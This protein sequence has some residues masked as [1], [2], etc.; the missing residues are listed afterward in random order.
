MGPDYLKGSYDAAK[1]N[2]IW[3]NAICLCG[4]QFKKHIIFHITYII[5]AP[6]CPAF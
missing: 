2:I 4:L 1:K 5:V 3:C 6:L